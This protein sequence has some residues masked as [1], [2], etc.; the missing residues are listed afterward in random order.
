MSSRNIFFI[1][2]VFFRVG[3]GL[4]RLSGPRWTGEPEVHV[5]HR[6]PQSLWEVQGLLS[7]DAARERGLRVQVEETQGRCHS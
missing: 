1:F 3:F 4:W 7:E 2:F 6:G 5:P